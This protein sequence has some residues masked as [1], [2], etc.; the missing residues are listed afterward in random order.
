MADNFAQAVL[1]K[2]VA[3]VAI[4]VGA[5]KAQKSVLTC[6]SD[7]A[8][9]YIQTI[10]NFATERAELSGRTEVNLFDVL[11]TF[12]DLPN[13]SVEWRDL[14]NFAFKDVKKADTI[15]GTNW[16]QPFP[17][18]EDLPIFPAERRER[19]QFGQ[20]LGEKKGTGDTSAKISKH[21]S[22]EQKTVAGDGLSA[23][24]ES[25]GKEVEPGRPAYLPPGFPALPPPHTY[26]RTKVAAVKRPA[27]PKLLR[28]TKLKRKRQARNSLAKLGT[29]A[30][31]AL[32]K[33][34]DQTQVDFSKLGEVE[35]EHDDKGSQF[36][37]SSAPQFHSKAKSSAA[38]GSGSDSSKSASILTRP[39]EAQLMGMK[40]E[41]M[42]LEGYLNEAQE[43]D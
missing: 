34:E 11:A 28:K 31:S 36:N 32:E 13:E 7:I 4:A 8:K 1:S 23:T 39:D 37:K 10:G 14:R 42:I 35:E 25:A 18:G 17:Q 15:D 33:E 19:R 2:S 21:S 29:A 3:H 26:K 22:S 24:T 9:R 40:K 6:L 27:D 38:L 43:G 20:K 41:D 16:Y 12:R 5:E 30:G